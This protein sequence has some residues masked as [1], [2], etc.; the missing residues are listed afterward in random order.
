MSKGMEAEEKQQSKLLHVLW[1]SE[2]NLAKSPK[3]LAKAKACV[4]MALAYSNAMHM[5]AC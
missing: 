1:M 3:T 4:L 2:P 5:S